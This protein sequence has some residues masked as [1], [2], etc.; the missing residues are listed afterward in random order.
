VRKE[1]SDESVEQ[2]IWYETPEGSVN[3]CPHWGVLPGGKAE[4]LAEADEEVPGVR[5][6]VEVAVT[7]D[8]EPVALEED[9]GI[10][11]KD[12]VVADS[13]AEELPL[14]LVAELKE[15]GIGEVPELPEE[16]LMLALMLLLE[17]TTTL[18]DEAVVAEL[19]AEPLTE[20]NLPGNRFR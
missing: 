15:L 6:V 8:E 9:A 4:A 13:D 12:V 11:V 16:R 2:K 20:L 5:E 14:S 18:E 10:V 19:V 17:L 1:P 3:T 7:P